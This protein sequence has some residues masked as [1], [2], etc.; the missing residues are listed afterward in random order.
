MTVNLLFG[1]PKDINFLTD[2]FS[3]TGKHVVCGGSTAQVVANFLQ[4]SV[5]T[6]LHYENPEIPPISKLKGLE[7][8]TEGIV[9]MGYVLKK[10]SEKSAIDDSQDGAS[11]LYKML[12]TSDE[13]NFFIGAENPLNKQFSELKSKHEL[14][15]SLAGL[16][17]NLGK[18]ITV[19]DV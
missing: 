16:L 11:L 19:R 5:I 13:I 1:P 4:E 18:K 15:A 7:L 3:L 14:V 8:V 12:R 9:T 10:F 6:S 17:T 2:F